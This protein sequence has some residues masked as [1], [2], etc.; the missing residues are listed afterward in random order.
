MIVMFYPDAQA[1]VPACIMGIF[2]SE[3]RDSD[4]DLIRLAV[5]EDQHA[6][7]CAD[8][9]FSKGNLE[10]YIEQEANNYNLEITPV[11]DYPKLRYDATFNLTIGLLSHFFH[12]CISWMPMHDY[13]KELKDVAMT[14]LDESIR[15]GIINAFNYARGHMPIVYDNAEWYYDED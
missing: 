7:D 8:Y 12:E 1:T 2:N 6:I 3:L 14:T 10:N 4:G 5:I 11:T 13:A 15:N 9:Q